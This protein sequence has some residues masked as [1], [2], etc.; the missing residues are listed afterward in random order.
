MDKAG[1]EL[2]LFNAFISGKKVNKADFV[3]EHHIND[4]TF[5]RDIENIRN[6]LAEVHSAAEIKFDKT[7]NFYY[8]QGIHLHENNG[9]SAVEAGKEDIGFNELVK[10]ADALDVS[11]D[12]L[13][14]R[15]MDDGYTEDIEYDNMFTREALDLISGCSSSERYHLLEVATRTISGYKQFARTGFSM[16]YE[17]EK[18]NDEVEE[19]MRIITYK[20]RYLSNREQSV[21][22][23]CMKL[24]L[25]QMRAKIEV[26]F[27]PFPSCEVDRNLLTFSNDL[28]DYKSGNSRLFQ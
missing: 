4:R 5:E 15:D 21:V 25:A 24:A 26:L 3:E 6:I 13:L 9:L 8:M 23:G 12:F 28:A 7:E 27:I 19:S 20:L 1:R 22:L 17:P 18:A 2:L 16:Q 11:T 14:G 10:F